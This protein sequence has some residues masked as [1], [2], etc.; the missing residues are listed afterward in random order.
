MPVR[1]KFPSIFFYD[2]GF[3]AIRQ[4]LRGRQR[5]GSHVLSDRQAAQ[6]FLN[7][8]TLIEAIMAEFDLAFAIYPGYA[9]KPVRIPGNSSSGEAML[10][11]LHSRILK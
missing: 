3:S 8:C 11:S 2:P 6:F 7:G 1:V 9:L 10:S 5:T 4:L